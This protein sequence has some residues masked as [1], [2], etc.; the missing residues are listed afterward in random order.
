MVDARFSMPDSRCLMLDARYW[1]HDARY[2]ILVSRCRMLDAW[3]SN[4]G[5]DR[6]LFLPASL[7][8]KKAVFGR[9]MRLNNRSK[10]FFINSSNFLQK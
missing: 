9:K 6:I 8:Y 5:Q 10:N 3:S 2:W 4:A 7:N 1:I